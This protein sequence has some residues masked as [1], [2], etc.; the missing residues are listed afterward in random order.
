MDGSSAELDRLLD[1]LPVAALCVAGDRVLARNP[2]ARSL[3]GPGLPAA[4]AGML[5]DPPGP[6]G[7]THRRFHLQHD[8][9]P[10][11]LDVTA[12]APLDATGARI[13]LL[14]E[15]GDDGDHRHRLARGL[16]FERLLTRSSAELMRSPEERLDAAIVEVLGA[17]GRFFGVDRSYVFRID[18][19]AATQSN[20]HEWVAPGISQEA[21]NLQ[22][23]PL[24]TFPWLL[25]RLRED[26]VFRFESIGDLPQEARN[27][28]AEFEREG[29]QSILIVPLWANGALRGFAGFDA[30]RCRVEWSDGYVVGLRL[31]AQMLAGALEARSMARSLRR[32]ALH[33]AVT[34][35][36]NRLYLRERFEQCARRLPAGARAGAM[37][38]VIDVDDFKVVNDRFG[39]ACGDSLLRELGGRFQRAVGDEGVVARVGGDEFVVVDPQGQGGAEAFARRLLDAAGE[40]FPVP[41]GVHRAGVS[42]GLVCGVHEDDALDSLLDR[43]DAAMYRAKASGKHQWALDEGLRQAGAA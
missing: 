40:P 22:D 33:D 16:E 20:T 19:A 14:R 36:P 42:I 2:A 43:A 18:E 11:A 26:A 35:L 32:Q 8:G 28:R 15:A 9:R 1:A 7:W 5:V 24:D 30:V 10:L 31:L 34:G 12:G 4:V 27:E 21:P 38:A 29:I 23:V 13:L 6:D 3:L 41:G 25:A 39:H 37:V 17:V